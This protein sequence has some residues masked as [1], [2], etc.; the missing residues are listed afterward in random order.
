ML[1][2]PSSLLPSYHKYTTNKR[3]ESLLVD[4]DLKK[5]YF[6]TVT[7]GWEEVVLH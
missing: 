2:T 7:T 4:N 5:I 1:V 6:S 3:C